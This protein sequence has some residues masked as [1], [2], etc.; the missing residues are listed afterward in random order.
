[1]DIGYGIEAGSAI[2]NIALIIYLFKIRNCIITLKKGL[3]KIGTTYDI[4]MKKTEYSLKADIDNMIG[5][6]E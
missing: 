4:H 1:M 6:E 3:R 2:V 5:E